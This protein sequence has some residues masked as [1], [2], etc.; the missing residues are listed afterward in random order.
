M[1]RKNLNP[2]TGTIQCLQGL[3]GNMG[4]CMWGFEGAHV[5]IWRGGG[6]AHESF[7]IDHRLGS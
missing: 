5:G 3:Y 2:S 6:K 4:K 1:G 7:C